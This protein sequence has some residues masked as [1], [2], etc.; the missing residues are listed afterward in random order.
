MN[1]LA[2]KLRNL[3]WLSAPLLFLAASGQ[4]AGHT[5]GQALP[6]ESSPVIVSSATNP[7]TAPYM[8]PSFPLLLGAVVR[9]IDDPPLGSR[10]LLTRNT[11]HPA[12]PG[13]LVPVWGGL[14]APRPGVPPKTL[15]APDSP[16]IRAGDPVIV[17]ENTAVAEARLE[18]VA[19]GAARAGA[20]LEVRLK[21][22]G[23]RVRA[24]AL[25][26]GRAALAPASISSGTASS[27]VR[28]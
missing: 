12:G 17:E 21:V 16:V 27:E 19:L 4:I 1:N 3:T 5:Q 26:P 15:P 28:P 13:R 9:E 6:P 2:I 10:W 8:G 18:G 25:G 20:G 23:A 7:G 11:I 22:G 14:T 24:V